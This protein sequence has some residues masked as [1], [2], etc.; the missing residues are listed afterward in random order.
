MY[1]KINY[2]EVEE[3]ME[4]TKQ[5]QIEEHIKSIFGTNKSH[6]EKRAEVK[7]FIEKS[8]QQKK[9][10]ILKIAKEMNSSQDNYEFKKREYDE[11]IADIIVY[12]K[13][14]DENER[15]LYI[16][17]YNL[18]KNTTL[19]K[20]RQ[21]NYEA[22]QKRRNEELTN[23]SIRKFIIK[24]YNLPEN[25]TLEEC[26]KISYLEQAKKKMGL[27]ST[28]TE[29]EVK[30][31]EQKE[32]SKQHQQ[33]TEEYKEKQ[34]KYYIAKYNLPIDTTYE[35]CVQIA[36]DSFQKE[37]DNISVASM[38]ET[39][40]TEQRENDESI[41]RFI[42]K[43]YNLPENTSLEECKKISYLEQAKKKMG[44]PS[45]ATEEEVKLAE[46]KEYSKQHQQAIEEYKEKQRKYYI[47]KYNLPENT[48]FEQCI[49]VNEEAFQ[50]EHE[51]PGVG[52]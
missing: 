11:A 8:L 28:A 24:E 6:K 50:K 33:A 31:A 5:R 38:K 49:Q 45:T 25:T 18:P 26:K 16:E 32:Y 19:R 4:T 12:G 35:E 23:E 30:L 2:M 13:M 46:Q 48:T 29:E 39:K 47:A 42:I 20:G 14:L 21:V 51:I 43:E 17:M 9:D 22:I 27:P 44:L 36:F 15:L 40:T 34:R 3:N 37:I 41:R 7:L 10:D 52:R 1:V